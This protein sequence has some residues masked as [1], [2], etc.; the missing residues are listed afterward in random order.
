M[1]SLSPTSTMPVSC[2]LCG[3]D[4]G[5]RSIAIHVPHCLK[6]WEDEQKKIPRSKRRSP[7]KRPE[8]LDRVIEGLIHGEELKEFNEEA[9]KTWNT[10]VLVECGHCL[11]T[12]FSRKVRKTPDVMHKREP[13]KNL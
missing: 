12:F 11:R 9:T 6:K 2:Y 13:M 1:G 8:K 5:L 3:R 7:P 4:Y 10:A